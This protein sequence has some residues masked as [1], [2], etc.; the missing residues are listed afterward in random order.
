[1]WAVTDPDVAEGAGG[2]E[3][4][5]LIQSIAAGS[6]DAL[7]ALYDR[8]AAIVFGL[9][10]RITTRSEDAEEVVQDVFA[11]VWRQAGRY[12]AGR[13][14]VAGWLVMLA[15]TRAIDR[16]RARKARPDQAAAV[17]PD[18]LAPVPSRDPNPEEVVVSLRDAG[19]VRQGL[20][21][22]PAEQR[23]L[24][25]M[26]FYGGLT[27]T[28]IAEETRLPLGTVKTRIRAAMFTLRDRLRGMR[29]P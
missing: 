26:A 3:D 27:H 7:A 11:Q 22:L 4:W 15:R 8:Y 16:T 24:V 10:R 5:R 25:E 17:E 2:P 20:E 12:Q 29:T 1:M 21:S 23:S 9:A 14:T 13:A 28:E 6:A 19:L 18:R